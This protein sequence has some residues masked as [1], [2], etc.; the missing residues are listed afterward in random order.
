[1][2]LYDATVP[3]RRGMPVFPG[4]PPFRMEPILRCS[5]GDPFNL[6]LMSVGTHL[7]TH[8]DPPLHYLDGTPGVDE[9]PLETLIGPGIVVDMGGR[10]E[11]NRQALEKA[12]L[13]GA[14]RVLFKTN[15]RA[16]LLDDAFHEEFVHL[17]LDA[18]Q[19]LVTLGVKLVGIDY[20]SIEHYNSPDAAVH[21]TL[22]EAG[23]LIVE[24]VLLAH[25]P[26]GLCRIYCLPLK[27]LGA[28]GAPARV[29]VE[30]D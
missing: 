21:R 13:R 22:L 11:I 24:G 20:L 7:G 29:V 28:D 25:V 5:H 3:L 16:M 10:A 30:T 18:A 8:V 19:W 6:S 26:A 15:N 12:D 4:D 9:I 14:V 2:P 17:T 27:I 23:V 1:M